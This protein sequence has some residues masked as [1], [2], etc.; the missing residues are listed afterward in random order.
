[1]VEQLRPRRDVSSSSLEATPDTSTNLD[2][3]R[4]AEEATLVPLSGN[5]SLVEH[6]TRRGG[7]C[8]GLCLGVTCT[9]PVPEDMMGGG[10]LQRE[11]GVRVG[12]KSQAHYKL[13]FVLMATC[14]ERN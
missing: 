10:R 13:D 8:H 9:Y 4:P 2:G 14:C 11:H 7:H 12:S 1:M 5:E 6:Q 3:P